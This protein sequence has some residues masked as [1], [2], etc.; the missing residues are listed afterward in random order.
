ME[1]LKRFW[2]EED[3]V[4]TVEVVLIMAVL[5]TIAVMFREKI[6]DFVSKALEKIFS[7][8][9]SVTGES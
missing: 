7:D 2:Q 8:A 6:T 9:K 4:E 1:L 5:V 3:G